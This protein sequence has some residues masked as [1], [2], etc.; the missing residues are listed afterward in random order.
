MPRHGRR[1]DRDHRYEPDIDG[2]I[3]VLLYDAEMHGTLSGDV[4]V[5]ENVFDS[6]MDLYFVREGGSVPA[7][8]PVPV[9]G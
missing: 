4:I 9:G 1:R 3:D 5:F 8:G 6:G 2:N 7:E